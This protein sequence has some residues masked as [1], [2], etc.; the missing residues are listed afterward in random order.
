[1]RAAEYWERYQ[2]DTYIKMKQGIG[3]LIRCETDKGKV[4]VLDSRYIQLK[5]KFVSID[6]NEKYLEMPE[7]EDAKA[8]AKT[9][10]ATAAL[11][12]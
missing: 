3:R 7:Q 9:Q 2:Y 5:E 8:K 4:V 12:L 11:D 6:E 10:T 1:M